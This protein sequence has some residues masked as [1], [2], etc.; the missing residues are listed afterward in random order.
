MHCSRDAVVFAILLI[1]GVLWAVGFVIAFSILLSLA[2]NSL[3][4]LPLWMVVAIS[5]FWFVWPTIVSS[6]SPRSG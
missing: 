5:V 4:A 1:L 2:R 3:A 6:D